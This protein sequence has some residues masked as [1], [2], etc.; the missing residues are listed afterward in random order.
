MRP[1]TP[2]PLLC[3]ETV[4]DARFGCPYVV[5]QHRPRPGLWVWNVWSVPQKSQGVSGHNVPAETS[6]SPTF[7]LW[8]T[9]YKLG[10]RHDCWTSVR[11]S[12]HYYIRVDPNDDGDPVTPSLFSV[13]C[14]ATPHYG[15][16]IGP[17]SEQSGRHLRISVR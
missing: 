17:L 9:F 16:G 8:G 11:T 5:D 1:P 12:S 3:L 4:R 7:L 6:P 15:F 13:S 14:S 2:N 10:G